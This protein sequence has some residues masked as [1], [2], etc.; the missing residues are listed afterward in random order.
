MADQLKVG[1]TFEKTITVTEDHAARHLTGKGTRVFSTPSMVRLIEECALEGV[2]PFLSPNQNTVGTRV[3][4]K[5]LAAT[6]VGMR[7]TVRCT[8]LEIDRRRL[9]FQAEVHDELDKVG[10]GINERF[11]VDAEKH[12]Q[13]IQEKLARWRRPA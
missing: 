6:P 4:V 12:Q 5:H 8:L 1:L 9:L 2:Q 10:E 3:D 13:R 7:I 11:I